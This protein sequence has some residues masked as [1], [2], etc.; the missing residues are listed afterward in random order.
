M[1][2]CKLVAGNQRTILIGTY[3]TPSTLDHLPDLEDV[4]NHLLGREPVI[5][6]DLNGDIGLLRKPRDQQVSDFLASFG[7]VDLLCHF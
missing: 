4:L 2:I 7:L 6:G 5:L 3:L 1:A